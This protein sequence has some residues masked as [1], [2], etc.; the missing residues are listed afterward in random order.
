LRILDS[1]APGGLPDRIVQ[2]IEVDGVLA[3]SH[4]L[5]AAP[6]SGWMDVPLGAVGQGS[7]KQVR[8]AVRAIRPDPGAAWGNAAQTTVQLSRE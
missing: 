3:L 2:S 1:Y 4:D 8:I 7:K 5:A 6:G